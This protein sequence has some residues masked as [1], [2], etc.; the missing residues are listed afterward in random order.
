MPDWFVRL[1]MVMTSVK[2]HSR[3][4]KHLHDLDML[5]ADLFALAAFDAGGRTVQAVALGAP[6]V[7]ILRG[8]L[9]VIYVDQV[10]AFDDARDRY[11]LR[12]S[13]HTVSA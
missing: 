8:A 3:L 9:T 5:R 6:V 11:R 7:R 1:V 13:F 2:D 10:H 4:L 12:A